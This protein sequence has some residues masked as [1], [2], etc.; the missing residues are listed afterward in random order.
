M[1]LTRMMKV[2][3]TP[4][5]TRPAPARLQPRLRGRGA[6]GERGRCQV[7]GRGPAAAGPRG[8]RLTQVRAR[9]AGGPDTQPPPCSAA[10]PTATAPHGRAGGRRA[11]DD[12]LPLRSRVPARLRAVTSFLWESTRAQI[13]KEMKETTAKLLTYG[14]RGSH[15]SRVLP[16]QTA[17]RRVGGGAATAAGTGSGAHG[18]GGA[19]SEPPRLAGLG[20][21][22]RAG[23]QSRRRETQRDPRT[24]N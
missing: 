18:A 11:G 9:Q 14:G 3:P 10:W 5:G 24:P 15:D 13:E 19:C 12:C 16:A 22:T 20:T 2:L 7:P 6:R 21:S 8:C 1:Y 23:V 4:A 17:P